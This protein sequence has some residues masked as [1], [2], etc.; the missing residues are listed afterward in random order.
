MANNQLIQGA[1]LTGREFLDVGKSVAEGLATGGER[2]NFV[3]PTIAK[4]KEIQASVN[5]AMGKMKTDMDFTSFSSAETRVMR[6]FLINKRSKYAAA[7]KLAAQFEDTTDP[8]YMEQV[9][10][11]QN[12]NN[13]FT[14]LSKQLASYKKGKVEYAE[15]QLKGIYSDGT[16]KED[17]ADIA[18]MYGFY[19][20]ND[21]KKFTKNE[22]GFDAPFVIQESGDIGFDIQGKQFTYNE[23]N[24]PILKDFKLATT[25]LQ[26]N[27]KAFKAGT[28][29]RSD[30]PSLKSY[31]VQLEQKL[32]NQDSLT[33]MLYDYQDELPTSGILE[34][35]QN[36]PD[37]GMPEARNE[38]INSLVQAR[39]DTS[40][41]GFNQAENEADR[42]RNILTAPQKRNKKLFTDMLNSINTDTMP[43]RGFIV[44]PGTKETIVRTTEG[45]INKWIIADKNGTIKMNE[46][47]G[48]ALKGYET[49]EDLIASL[50]KSPY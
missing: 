32:Q 44:I 38:F 45:A 5:R 7:A 30:D 12:V 27:E 39:I 37:Y 31:R 33:S 26:D 43:Y 29:I 9:D 41:A 42:K 19:D 35:L 1:K 36:N 11:M 8:A 21:D 50:P 22:G 47:T 16:N 48:E 14:N 20:E 13:S 34:N 4:N 24:Q 18:Q 40:V 2:Q 28:I 17:G 3:D 6:D 23:T 49:N 25:I 46:K 15:G 10:I